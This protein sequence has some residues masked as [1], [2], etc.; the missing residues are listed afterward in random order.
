MKAVVFVKKSE[1]FPGKHMTKIGN[2]TMIDSV[3]SRILKSSMKSEVVVF[4]KDSSVTTGLC[5]VVEDTTEGTI[6]D[7][8]LAA[9]LKFGDIFAFAGDMPCISSDVID[10]MIAH[11]KGTS[12]IPVHADGLI[13]PLHSIYLAE[14]AQVLDS[15]IKNEKRSIREFISRIPHR[16]YAIPTERELSF[17]NVNYP[18]DLEK[19]RKEGCRE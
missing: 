6:V 10:E 13:E 14:F 18:G 2:T 3:V 16:M 8:I 17:Y 1:R 5:E 7:S 4:T 19:L 9:L 15:N 11:S 12:L